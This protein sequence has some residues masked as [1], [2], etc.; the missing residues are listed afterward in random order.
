MSTLG[1]R[2]GFK[3]EREWEWKGYREVD[4]ERERKREVEGYRYGCWGLRSEIGELEDDYGKERHLAGGGGEEKSQ[5]R[6]EHY[7]SARRAWQKR[8]GQM[9]DVFKHILRDSS[10]SIKSLQT[11]LPYAV[12]Q[13]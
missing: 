8:K 10:R 6:G 3:M 13:P 7:K 9:M 2:D 1:T 11:P 12:H 4:S 5:R